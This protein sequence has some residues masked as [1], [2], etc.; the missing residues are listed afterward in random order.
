MTAP[1]AKR[2]LDLSLEPARVREQYGDTLP[3]QAT[4]A[5]RRLIEAGVRFVQVN[6]CRTVIQQGWD[7]H[8][9]GNGGSIQE[10]KD[11]LLP[12]LDQAGQRASRTWHSGAWTGIPSW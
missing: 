1:E 10:M 11:Y 7:T 6:W 12:T 5:A 8:G 9:R 2:A 4:L 3:G